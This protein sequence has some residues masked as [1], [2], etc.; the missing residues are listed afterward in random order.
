MIEAGIW[1]GILALVAGMAVWLWRSGGQ[2]SAAKAEVSRLEAQNAALERQ[3]KTA[4]ELKDLSTKV[5]G[6]TDE[7]LDKELD[8]WRKP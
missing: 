4:K 8:R 6:L 7:E 2:T 3:L 1:A 5:D